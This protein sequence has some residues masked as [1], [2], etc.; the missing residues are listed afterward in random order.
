MGSSVI[1]WSVVID[2]SVIDWSV[3]N[4]PVVVE[5]VVLSILA[6]VIVKSK[7]KGNGSP[8]G[9]Y[10]NFPAKFQI[11]ILNLNQ[12]VKIPNSSIMCLCS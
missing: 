12:V 10:S 9:P 3:I 5:S 1:G 7:G 4:R 11:S 2:W 8:K 6:S